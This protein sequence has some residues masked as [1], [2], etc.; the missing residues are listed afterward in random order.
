[1]KTV[2]ILGATSPIGAA[3]SE[4]FSEGNRVILSGRNRTR[5][6]SVAARC[7]KAGA[8]ATKAVA[9]DLAQTIQP[10][11]E[12]N[13]EWPIE[14]IVDAASATSGASRVRDPDVPY[15]AMRGL[16]QADVLAHLD[17]YHAVADHNGRFPDVIFISTILS[18]VRTPGREIYSTTKRLM[19]IYL[20]KVALD[21]PNRRV[22]IYRIGTVI[23]PEEDSQKAVLAA[24]H[25]KQ[26]FSSG[27][28]VASYGRSGQILKALDTIHPLLLRT[29]VRIQRFLRSRRDHLPTAS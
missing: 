14:L 21:D 11:V 6:D 24:S 29:A 13:A 16:I 22:L 26:M 7:A 12:A 20:E 27:L 28:T 15:S 5:L 17:I 9:A 10:I 4:Q 2:L 19:E 25:A 3:L 8:F 23:S 18:V 1:M